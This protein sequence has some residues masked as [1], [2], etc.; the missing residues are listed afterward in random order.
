MQRPQ[1]C[2]S[3]ECRG[4]FGCGK[5]GADA[6]RRSG[7]AG[8]QIGDDEFV[9]VAAGEDASFRESCLIEAAARLDNRS[10]RSPLS[11]RMLLGRSG[12]D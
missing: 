1:A 12:V 9:E 3:A 8:K 6:K 10:A 7:S 11:R 2:T 5:R 4:V